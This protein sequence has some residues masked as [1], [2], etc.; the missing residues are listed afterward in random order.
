MSS[1]SHF[2]YDDKLAKQV[3]RVFDK[4]G[5]Q[6]G[7]D[8]IS[9]W[10][11]VMMLFASSYDPVNDVYSC[12][13]SEIGENG[14]PENYRETVSGFCG[15][16]VKAHPFR[17][18]HLSSISDPETCNLELV[19]GLWDILKTVPLEH[20][21]DIAGAVLYDVIT[22]SYASNNGV[23][24]TPV[25]ICDLANALL[26]IPENQ[27]VS[28]ADPCV[29]SGRMFRG[30]WGNPNVHV[31]SCDIDWRASISCVANLYFYRWML[32]PEMRKQ[33]YEKT[34]TT[35]RLAKLMSLISEVN[36]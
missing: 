14:F 27:P 33:H 19:R 16:L 2:D 23:F 28:I 22:D 15:K 26:E 36:L 32:N 35:I 10:C 12:F 5:I 31:V 18:S 6:D 17:I 29:G 4:C 7:H 20:K 25:E 8:Q 1:F 21:P 9:V 13:H 34:E 30:Q 24:P 11:I 3:N